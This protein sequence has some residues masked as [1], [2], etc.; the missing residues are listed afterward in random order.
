MA[1]QGRIMLCGLL[2]LISLVLSHD[3]SQLNLLRVKYFKLGFCT[4]DL[5]FHISVFIQKIFEV[6]LQAF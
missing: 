3:L 2:A 4:L 6:V 1:Q 5:T